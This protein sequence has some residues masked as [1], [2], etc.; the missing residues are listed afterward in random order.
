MYTYTHT[1]HTRYR[2]ICIIDVY[3]D[4]YVH[5]NYHSHTHTHTHKP[6]THRYR[7]IPAPL[8]LFATA[9]PP[10]CVPVCESACMHGWFAHRAKHSTL[11]KPNYRAQCAHLPGAGKPLA[12]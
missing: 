7:S 1:R 6:H 10:A 2:Y 12:V 9:W 4:I 5:T 3:I 11:T 8:L